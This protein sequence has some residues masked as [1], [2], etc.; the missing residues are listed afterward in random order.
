MKKKRIISCYV[1]EL[2]EPNILADG[3]VNF[4]VFSLNIFYFMAISAK[5]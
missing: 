3:H 1:G 4:F 2:R 5:P